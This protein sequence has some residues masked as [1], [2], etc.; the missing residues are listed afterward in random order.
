MM[1]G[2]GTGQE[3]QWP[4]NGIAIRQGIH[5]EWQRTICPGWGGSAIFAWS[6]TRNGDRD[7]FIQKVGFTGTAFWDDEGIA[8]TTLP[9]RQED[10][11]IVEDGI[12]GAFVAWVDYRFDEEGDIFIQHVDFEGNLQMD[13][14]GVALC[15]Q[16]GR[17]Y[18]INMATDSAGGVFVCWQ[19]SRNGLDEDIYC[20][21]VSFQDEVSH[22]GSGTAIIEASG[23]QG[24]KSIEYAGMNE[25]LVIWSDARISSDNLD[26]YAQR[27][28]T[29]ME[30]RFPEDGLPIATTNELEYR[31]K[32]AFL[33][34]VTSVLVWQQGTTT[35]EVV[36]Q[37]V[38]TSGLMFTSEQTLTHDPASKEGPRIKRSPL[39]SVFAAWE[40]FRHDALEPAFYVQRIGP[41]GSIL[42]DSAGIPMDPTLLNQSNTR[43]IADDSSGVVFVWERGTHP[44]ED[45]IVQHF[46][47]SGNATLP[48][49]G[50]IISDA[51]G[52]Q[53]SPIPVSDEDV[54]Q[55]IVFGDWSSGS[56]DLRIQILDETYALGFI[57]NGLTVMT[58]LDGDVK[59]GQGVPL[60]NGQVVLGWQDNRYDQKLFAQHLASGDVEIILNNGTQIGFTSIEEDPLITE[61]VIQVHDGIMHTAVFDNSSGFDLVRVNRI[62]SELENVWDSTGIIIHDGSADQ[63]RAFLAPQDDGVICFWSEI[64]NQI[65]YDIYFQRLDSDGNPQLAADGIS[66][67]VESFIDEYVV[68]VVPVPGGDLIV[69]WEEDVWNSGVIKYIRL[70]GSSPADGWTSG[71]T[72]SSSG[73]PDGLVTKVLRDSSG[74]YMVWEAE[75]SGNDQDVFMQGIDWDGNKLMGNDPVNLSNTENSQVNASVAI[76]G[77]DLALVVWEDFRNGDSYSIFGQKIDLSS[78]ALIDTNF[79]ICCDQDTFYRQ[80]PQVT[81]LAGDDYFVVWEDERG[82]AVSDPLLSGGLDLYGARV[83]NGVADD[84]VVIAAEYHSQKTPQIVPIG[85][86]GSNSWLLHWMDL[87]SSGKAEL[88]NLYG[89]VLHFADVNTTDPLLVPTAFQVGSAFPNPF[90]SAVQIPISLPGTEPVL[91]TFFNI[92]GQRVYQSTVIPSGP[93]KF[94]FTWAGTDITGKSLGSGIYLYQIKSND[95]IY[96]GKVSYLK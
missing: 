31:P 60:E 70:S 58:G 76:D 83:S 56:I 69:F 84:P 63:R 12:G 15:Q 53:F 1:F 55:F 29:E 71:V 87:R 86:S 36:Y 40:D 32:T 43:F 14:S 37:L 81:A 94:Q 26:V 18:A 4:E 16:D 73:D 38:D 3:A 93:G 23:N 13:S 85:G 30:L 51:S 22:P 74:V 11:V 47:G 62:N 88:T 28:N 50:L 48:D 75:V 46:D 20:T 27:F 91:V 5:I 42:W 54:G 6:D 79:L 61:P 82:T 49:S 19:D 67:A 21:H 10:P 33:N 78:N 52:Y 95:I 68:A 2:I 17:Q 90:N 57:D 64:R 92:L 41:T 35:T 9:G 89:Q 34:D 44:Y 24:S 39:G 66:L 45:I 96:K 25:A 80:S 72:L 8:V 77:Q 65:S 7:V 59:Y